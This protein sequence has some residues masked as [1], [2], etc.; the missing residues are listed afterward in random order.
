MSPPGRGRQIIF[1]SAG[2][3]PDKQNGKPQQPP[4]NRDVANRTGSAALAWMKPMH[5]TQPPH[6]KP[7][8]P[9]PI[10]LK[11]CRQLGNILEQVPAFLFKPLIVVGQGVEITGVLAPGLAESLLIAQQ[12]CA[13]RLHMCEVFRAMVMSQ[14]RK[15]VPARREQLAS[16]L[17]YR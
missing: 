8:A 4:P 13:L 1:R 2:K 6:L 9:L 10:F 15:R 14:S 11:I 12:G 5:P 3:Y 17:V 7:V 16:I